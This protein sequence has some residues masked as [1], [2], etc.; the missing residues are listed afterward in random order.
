MYGP[1]GTNH[2]HNTQRPVGRRVCGAFSMTSTQVYFLNEV[3]WQSQ[4]PEFELSVAFQPTTNQFR[5]D[6]QLASLMRTQLHK[7]FGLN[8][9]GAATP[10]PQ[11]PSPF[12]CPSM[13]S[14]YGQN[15][16]GGF[17]SFCDICFLRRHIFTRVAKLRVPSMF[18][19]CCLWAYPLR[20]SV[21]EAE[22]R[23]ETVTVRTQY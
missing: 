5:T 3:Q 6:R 15:L 22:E 12:T 2:T 10:S 9:T 19:F 1:N 13:H 8:I 18:P 21:A 7:L 20:G 17:S 11:P 23:Y 14:T 4:L 16:S